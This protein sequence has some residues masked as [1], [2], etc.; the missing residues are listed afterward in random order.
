MSMSMSMSFHSTAPIYAVKSTSYNSY[1]ILISPQF[2]YLHP[3]HPSHTSPPSTTNIISFP[4]C[5]V[6]LP[7]RH[8][9]E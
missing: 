4:A 9:E 7:G 2:V 1:N 3:A 8:V 6:I 5:Y